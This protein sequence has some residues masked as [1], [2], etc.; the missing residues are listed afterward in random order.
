MN[1]KQYIRSEIKRTLKEISVTGTGASTV[2]GSGEQYTP[3]NFVNPNKKAKG[4]K[5]NY[6]VQKWGW[7]E[8]DMDKNRKN[9]K[10]FDIVKLKELRQLIKTELGN[11]SNNSINEGYNSFKKTVTTKSNRSATRS[12]INQVRRKIKEIEKVISY[13]SKLKEELGNEHIQ[14]EAINDL[15]VQLNELS[16]KLRSIVG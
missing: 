3:K 7:E 12:M 10:T 8:V 4:T 14:T 13:T 16:N 5:H 15:A 11:H 9:S 6:L 1:L 2:G